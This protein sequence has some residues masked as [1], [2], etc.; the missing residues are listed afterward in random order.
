M[1]L[2]R[3]FRFTVFFATSNQ[4][5]SVLVILEGHCRAYVLCSCYKLNDATLRTRPKPL[6]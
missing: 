6:V 3:C 5:L 2:L 1:L 4:M